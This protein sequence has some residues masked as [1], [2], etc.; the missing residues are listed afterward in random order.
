MQFRQE[1]IPQV[2]ENRRTTISRRSALKAIAGIGALGLS[3]HVHSVEGDQGMQGAL[4]PELDVSHWIDGDGQQAKAFSVAAQRGKWV[5]LK[6]FQEWCPSCHSVGF[7]NLQ[8][9][10]AAFPDDSKVAAAVIQTTFE[11]HSTNTV[12]ALRKNQLRYELSLP[13]GHDPGNDDLPRSD[14]GHYPN[15]MR[16]YRT[17]GTPWVTLIDPNG[18]VVFSD[19]H[20]D[21]ERLIPHLKANT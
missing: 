20:I 21:V 2:K 13:F 11:G 9:L 8:K 10:K 18:I 4:A 14:P 12:N 6:C 19:F 17:R 7:P 1:S 16:S 15:T 3:Q 5:Y